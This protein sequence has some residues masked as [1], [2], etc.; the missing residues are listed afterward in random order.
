ME[1][2]SWREASWRRHLEEASW[3]RNHGGDIMKESSRR[4]LGGSLEAGVTIG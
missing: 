4:H 3:M 2:T 1:E